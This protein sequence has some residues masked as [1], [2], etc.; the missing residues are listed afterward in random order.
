MERQRPAGLVGPQMKG[1][2]SRVQINFDHPLDPKGTRVEPL[3]VSGRPTV[4][5]VHVTTARGSVVTQ[6]HQ[7]S[8]KQLVRVPS[9]RTGFLRVTL[10]GVAGPRPLANPGLQ[11]ISVPG[12]HVRMYLKAPEEAVGFGAR[13]YSILVPGGTGRPHKHLTLRS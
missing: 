12:V 6:L 5:A 13:R 7:T 11:A 4:T 1:L 10:V 8:T 3:I 9:G 2:A